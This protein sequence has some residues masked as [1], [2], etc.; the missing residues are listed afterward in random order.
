MTNSVTILIVDDMPDNVAVLFAFL[1]NAGFTVLVAQ[2]G[3]AAIQVLEHAHPD[4]ILLDVMMP[5]MDGFMVCQTL[6]SREDT[7]EIPIIFM[8]ALTDTVDK[9]KGFKLGA[10]DYITKPIH[11]EEVLARINAHVRLCQQQQRI[12]E[13]NHELQIRNKEL[14]AF[15]HMVAHDLKNPL[16]GI[17]MITRLLHEALPSGTVVDGK[18]QERL[19]VIE[20]AGDKML[21]IINALLLLAGV[22]NQ[23]Q[24]ELS[25]LDMQQ[26]V[27]PMIQGRLSQLLKQFNGEI[28]LPKT[29]HV[30][31]GYSPW[32]EEIWV[33]YLSNGLKYGGSPPRLTLG[34]DLLPNQMVRF[35]VRDC[36]EG[37]TATEQS[38]LFTPFTRLQTSR[39]DGHGIGLSIVKQII[40]K[41][42]ESAGVESEKG[43]GS[44]FYFT[45]PACQ[46]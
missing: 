31:R 3:E 8:T 44:L 15:A 32:V 33:N 14:D 30:A 6:K 20:R 27:Q 19:G 35:W 29:W 10:A 23:K 26:I 41:L 16:N 37:L 9:V 5:G 2:D 34:S 12:Q 7:R 17:I 46:V 38:R 42:G 40:E 39:V 43:K 28:I 36:G 24:V 25:P 13:Q 21:N 45:L 4:L 1:R 18:V 22:S 11:H